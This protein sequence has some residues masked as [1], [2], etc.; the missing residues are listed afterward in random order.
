MKEKEKKMEKEKD[1]RTVNSCGTSSSRKANV[2]GATKFRT[3][4]FLA[5]RKNNYFS[6]KQN[7][8]RENK[9]IFFV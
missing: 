6:Q 5:V 2:F 3:R 9:R 1:T 4:A 7:I 8:F